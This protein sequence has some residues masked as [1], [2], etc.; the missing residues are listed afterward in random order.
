MVF[1][2][3]TFTCLFSVCGC[4]GLFAFSRLLFDL[5]P[6]LHDVPQHLAVLAD[7]LPSGG[8]NLISFAMLGVV[9]TKA[10]TMFSFKLI[11]PF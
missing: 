7:D 4:N 10:N 2:E 6:V 8:A 11:E 5:V 9:N 3:A 1:W